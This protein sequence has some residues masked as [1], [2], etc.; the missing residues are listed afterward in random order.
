[1]QRWHGVVCLFC[2]WGETHLMAQE[3][4]VTNQKSHLAKGWLQCISGTENQVENNKLSIGSICLNETTYKPTCSV[5][6]NTYDLISEITN[7]NINITQAQ[8]TSSVT[9][10][11]LTQLLYYLVIQ[12]CITNQNL[13]SSI[14]SLW[15]AIL[16]SH[17]KQHFRAGKPI[18]F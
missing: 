7:S 2:C 10:F 15:S 6:P 12:N 16:L 8:E 4:P 1:M 5:N 14:Q 9:P 17:P 13:L 18:A 11:D 3:L